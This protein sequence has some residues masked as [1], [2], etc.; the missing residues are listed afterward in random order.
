MPSRY[1][2]GAT[3]LAALIVACGGKKEQ[4]EDTPPATPAL[5]PGDT[6]DLVRVR[7]ARGSTSGIVN[8]SL[9]GD[10]SRGYLLG[11]AR[12]QVMLVH[13]ITWPPRAGTATPAPAA[14]QVFSLEDGNELESPAA[15]ESLWSGR[16]PGSGDYVVRVSAS[17][18]LAY[19]L[20]M[21]IPRRLNPGAAGPTASIVG[22]APSRAPVDYIVQGD[23]GQTLAAIVPD[24]D[25]ATLHI[26]GLDRGDQL[27]PLAERRKEWSG[28]L[29]STQDYIV[30]VVPM[31]EG[32]S[33]ELTVTVR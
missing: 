11:A 26:Y 23:E 5:T 17:A 18:P 24:R 32:A 8:D 14:V 16:L 4:P 33:Y 2:T 7:F 9:Q 15:Q 29:P 12:G 6:A 3:A 1:R 28:K 20:A 13:A 22:A 31:D 30:S 25:R 10:E 27:A 19:T 21:Q